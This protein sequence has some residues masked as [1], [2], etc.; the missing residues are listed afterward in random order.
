MPNQY[1][2]DPARD[3][4]VAAYADALG[5]INKAATELKIS[6][7]AAQKAVRRHL[8]RTLGERGAVVPL[9]GMRVA[10][11]TDQYDGRGNLKGYSVRQNGSGVESLVEIDK[12]LPGFALKR[13]ST[14]Y[15]ADGSIGQQWQIQS[16][17]R[18]ALADSVRAFVE[19]ICEGKQPGPPAY[20]PEA[21]D[22]DL[23]CVYPMGDPHFGMRAHAPEAGENFDLKIAETITKAVVDRLVSAAPPAKTA[24]LANMG[25]FFHADDNSARTKQSGNPLDVD[26][27][28]HEVLRVGGWTMV[29]LVYRLLE[30]HSEVIVFNERGN[31][32]DV[33]AI[34]MAVALDMYFHNNPRV[35]IADPAPYYHFYEFGKNLLGFTHGDGAKENDLPVLMANDEPQ[36]WGRTEHRVFH[37]GH[38]HHDREIDLTGCTVQTHRT[39]AASDAWHRKTGYRAKRSMKVITY[40]KDFGEISRNS[41]NLD[42]LK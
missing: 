35:K 28:W 14:N 12:T 24:I 25:D 4:E 33:S 10:E 5:S 37:R 40:H 21:T 39:L 42:V 19:G 9:P 1:D 13:V 2:I 29:H 7:A 6:R 30:K 32:D 18:A 15:R 38:F 8:A 3:A 17:E 41:V 34:A 11:V 27:R 22:N 20:G 31:H 36:A 26:G 16:P 23:L